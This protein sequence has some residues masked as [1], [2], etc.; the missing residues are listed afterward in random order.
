MSLTNEIKKNIE[1]RN[2]ILNNINSNFSITDK[3]KKLLKPNSKKY[4]LVGTIVDYLIRIKLMKKYNQD[5]EEYIKTTNCYKAI[6]II[7]PSIIENE[8]EKL[9][10][11]LLNNILL[12][13]CFPNLIKKAEQNIILPNIVINVIKNGYKI[14][15]F[16]CIVL[17]L[18]SKSG[19]IPMKYS[20]KNV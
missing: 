6:K 15:I 20:L 4:D 7:K 12:S 18:S 10:Y 11:S 16:D 2:V 8:E 1:F 13:T 3:N 17:A 19:F 9:D 14:F 5:I